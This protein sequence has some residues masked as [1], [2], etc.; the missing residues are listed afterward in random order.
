MFGRLGLQSIHLRQELILTAAAPLVWGSFRPEN[1]GK[2]ASFIFVRGET[3]LII[4]YWEREIPPRPSFSAFLGN[5]DDMQPPSIM[6]GSGYT[7]ASDLGTR[8]PYR[9]VFPNAVIC[10]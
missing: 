1:R 5:I 9:G 6:W 3:C 7:V 4:S 8:R 2:V 10:A